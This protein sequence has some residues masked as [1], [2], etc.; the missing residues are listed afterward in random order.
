MSRSKRPV[1]LVH[2]VS[3]RKLSRQR[4]IEIL[5]ADP[6]LSVAASPRELESKPPCD[7]LVLV[8]D[9]GSLK[10]DREEVL[11]DLTERHR[12]AKF[13]LVRDVVRANDHDLVALRLLGIHE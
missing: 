11:R 1:T 8:I 13:V 6:E 9:A 10:S 5:C 7:S 4:L 3:D 12:D 2:V